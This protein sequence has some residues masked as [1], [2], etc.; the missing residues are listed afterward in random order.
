M[1]PGDLAIVI[2]DQNKGGHYYAFGY[3]L[4][5]SDGEERWRRSYEPNQAVVAPGHNVCFINGTGAEWVD[6]T[7]TASGN[8]HWERRYNGAISVKAPVPV[9]L[10][11]PQNGSASFNV[12]GLRSGQKDHEAREIGEG[13]EKIGE[14]YGNIT[15]NN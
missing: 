11:G 15:I 3:C 14:P 1:G 12:T 13:E 10:T 8:C 6:I 9:K 2:I 7:L 4:G 5:N